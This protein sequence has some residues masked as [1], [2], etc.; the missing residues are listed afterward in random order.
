[1]ATCRPFQPR[2]RQDIFD[3]ATA[4]T[5]QMMVVAGQLLGQF[6]SAMVVDSGNPADDTGLDQCG[7]IPVG[8]GL[9][10]RLVG[11]NDLGDRKGT[12]GRRQRSHQGAS[13][14]RVSLV[15]TT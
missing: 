10:E 8:T 5:R 3:G 6:K 7:H 13:D 4:G 2:R 14:R 12:P 9:G 11:L 1:M 15:E